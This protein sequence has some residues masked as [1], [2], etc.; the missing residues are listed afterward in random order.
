MTLSNGKIG[1]DYSFKENEI[2]SLV[3]ESPTLFSEFVGSLWNQCD[4]RD[5]SFSLYENDKA[6]NISKE[7]ECLVNPFAVDCNDKKIIAALYK[8]LKTIADESYQEEVA[9]TNL[10]ILNLLDKISESSFYPLDYSFES[11]IISLLKLYDVHIC[12]EEDT[13]IER[14]LNYFRLKKKLC[15]TSIFVAVNIHQYLNK[16]DI[17]ELYK[18]LFYEKIFFI[19]VE[20]QDVPIYPNEKRYIIDKDCCIIDID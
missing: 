19:S 20:S 8:E 6:H 17:I 13:L 7:M 3:I 2:L 5:G 14:L 4:G 12:L 15:D 18:S 11:D 10:I 1:F 16:E 9:S